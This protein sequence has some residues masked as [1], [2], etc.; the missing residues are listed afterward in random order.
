MEDKIAQNNHLLDQ[1]GDANEIC[2]C[3]EK[4][5]FCQ[6][7]SS[8]NVIEGEIKLI[9]SRVYERKRELLEGMTQELD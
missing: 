3:E 8:E 2:D 6:L 7:P 4:N 5:M 1:L 9:L